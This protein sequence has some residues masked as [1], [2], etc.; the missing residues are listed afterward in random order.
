MRTLLLLST[1]LASNL[2]FAD[3]VGVRASAGLWSYDVSGVVRDDPSAANNVDLKA[4][5]GINED[6]VFNGF[7]YIEHPVPLLPNVRLGTTDLKLAGTGTTDGFT[8]NGTPVPA[9]TATSNVDL[10]HT[11]IGLY[12]EIID[13][14]FDLDLG[15]NVKL[16]DGTVTMTSGGTTAT[17]SFDETIPMLYASVGVPL[18]AGFAIGGDFSYVSY[19]GDKFQ[20]YFL[21][22]R[23]VSD[24]LLGVEVGYRSF[25]IDYEDGDEF[26]DAKIDGPYVNVRLEF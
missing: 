16:F 26:A 14:G 1:L 23:W 2:A 17:S 5:L 24:F 11:E 6:E 25:T 8:W 18:I 3:A 15:V 4:D 21:N 13:V 22:V 10:S 9:G 19:D 12:Y 7:V 20:D